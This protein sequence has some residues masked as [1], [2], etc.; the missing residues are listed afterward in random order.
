MGTIPCQAGVSVSAWTTVGMSC[1]RTGLVSQ[2]NRGDSSQEGSRSLS[3]SLFFKHLKMHIIFEK[4]HGKLIIKSHEPL[5]LEPAINC[6]IW[7]IYFYLFFAYT[8]LVIVIISIL[9]WFSGFFDYQRM[10][11]KW[12]SASLLCLFSNSLNIYL[13]LTWKADVEKW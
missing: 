5:V 9:K 12:S 6:C 4:L 8:F 10:H 2:L 13:W 3:L 11:S 1:W 7:H